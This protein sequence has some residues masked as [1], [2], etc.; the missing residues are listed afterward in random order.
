LRWVF[1]EKGTFGLEE[2]LMAWYTHVLVAVV[3]IIG[4]VVLG[5]C[6]LDEWRDSRARRR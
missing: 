1:H 6:C 4:V 2:R 5:S 3:V